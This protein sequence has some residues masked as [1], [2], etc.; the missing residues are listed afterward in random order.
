MADTPNTGP[1]RTCCGCG[2]RDRQAVLVR[3]ALGPGGTL[4]A[5]PARRQGGRGAYVHRSAPCWDGFV[6]GRPYVRSLRRNISRN[7]RRAVVETLRPVR[8]HDVHGNE[9]VSGPMARA[10]ITGD[11]WN[12]SS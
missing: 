10:G 8:E 11:A 7:E 3:L 4:V 2:K 6:R 1:L 12:A 9:D 5:D